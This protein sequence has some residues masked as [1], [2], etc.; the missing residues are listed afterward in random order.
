MRPAMRCQLGRLRRSD[1]TNWNAPS[2]LNT[3]ALTM[4]T[5]TGIGEATNRALFGVIS[6]LLASS[7]RRNAP[8]R[9]GMM[10]SAIS[11]AGTSHWGGP[12]VLR[13]P[14]RLVLG[15]TG[16]AAATS[17]PPGRAA[18]AWTLTGQ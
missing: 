10:L 1:G 16:R 4:C 6:G 5:V 9:M 2:K 11:P 3:V 17:V 18:A 8:A 15:D 14:G 7:V 12:F 13:R